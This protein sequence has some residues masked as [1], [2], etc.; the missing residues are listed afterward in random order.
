MEYY[1]LINISVS[2]VAQMTCNYWLKFLKI[3]RTRVIQTI[4]VNLV[5]FQFPFRST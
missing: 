3:Q 1:I 2:S 5:S 4:L